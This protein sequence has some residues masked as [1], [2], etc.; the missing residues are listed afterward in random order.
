MSAYRQ[1]SVS[2]AASRASTISS[3]GR[4]VAVSLA[5]AGEQVEQGARRRLLR[6]VKNF[7]AGGGPV[8]AVISVGR[9]L[10]PVPGLAQHVEAGEPARPLRGSPGRAAHCSRRRI[11]ASRPMPPTMVTSSGAS[12]GGPISML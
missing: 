5:L 3:T 6:S 10:V 1:P 8:L 9:H 11:A 4:P 2:P 12:S 7:S